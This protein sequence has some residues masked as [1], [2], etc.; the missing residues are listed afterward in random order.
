[1]V[2]A[3]AVAE[4]ARL[5]WRMALRRASPPRRPRPARDGR[6]GRRAR[7]PREWGAARARSRPRC[8]AGP[9][10]APRGSPSR[11]GSGRP[12][13][14]RP[15]PRRATRRS[16]VPRTPCPH[17]GRA[18]QSTASNTASRPLASPSPTNRPASDVRAPISSASD[19]TEPSTARSAPT[20]RSSPSSRVRWATVIESVLKIVKA[21]TG[22]ATPPNTSRTTRMIP[23]KLL[24]AVE[25]EAV[26]GGGGE[27][28]GLRHGGGDRRPDLRRRHAV[29]PAGEDAVDPVAA[30]E[31]L[32]RRAQVE[33]RGRSSRRQRRR[34]T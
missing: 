11:P 33:H 28:R 24:Q 31:Q 22:M 7:A 16:C 13:A 5:G 4:G 8:R 29:A 21:P 14:S 1:M 27:H 30:L 12:G 20:I 26:L 19:S 23:M 10:P 2:S 3:V 17:R 15:C 9:P 34:T 6:G 32:L 25:R 18:A